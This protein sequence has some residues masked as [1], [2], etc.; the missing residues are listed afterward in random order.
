M[1]AC[2]DLRGVAAEHVAAKPRH[3]HAIAHQLA[4]I[5]IADLGQRIALRGLQDEQLEIVDQ[6]CRTDRPQADRRS[7]RTSVT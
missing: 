7:A 1:L 4:Q 2:T 6:C 5:S 3:P